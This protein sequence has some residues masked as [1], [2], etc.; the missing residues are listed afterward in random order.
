MEGSLCCY[1]KHLYPATNTQNGQIDLKCPCDQR[2][3]DA[4]LVNID[5]TQIRLRLFPIVLAAD[6]R[7]ATEKLC[8]NASLVDDTVVI[9][10]KASIA[11]R[12]MQA[13]GMKIMEVD[14]SEFI[15]SG[16]SVHNLKM[17]LY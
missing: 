10:K 3:L 14:T 16:S 6:E 8:C 13:I 17:Q 12:H 9:Q 11:I 4:I 2:H 15:K 5:F 7:E 1:I